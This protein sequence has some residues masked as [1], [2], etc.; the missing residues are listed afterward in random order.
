MR[1]AE[2]NAKIYPIRSIL[3]V[4]CQSGCV[5]GCDVERVLGIGK[6]VELI[7]RDLCIEQKRTQDER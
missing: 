1:R 3:R 7:I 4:S 2:K 6:Y 5:C